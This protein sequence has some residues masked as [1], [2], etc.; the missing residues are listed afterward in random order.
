MDAMFYKAVV[1][2]LLRRYDE[3]AECY[4]FFK[5]S[6]AYEEK[7]ALINTVFGLIMLP[8]CQDRRRILNVA[9]DLLQYL[10]FY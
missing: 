3:A 7:K 5:K 2:R 6:T 1:M 9:E 8:L 10:K 4:R